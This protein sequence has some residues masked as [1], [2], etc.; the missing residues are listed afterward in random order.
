MAFEPDVCSTTL[1]SSHLAEFVTAYLNAPINFK[2]K[3]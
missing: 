3:L 2:P 1:E